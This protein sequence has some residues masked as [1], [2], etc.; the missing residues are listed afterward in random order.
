M[1]QQRVWRLEC[2]IDT[3][4]EDGIKIAVIPRVKE[5]NEPEKLVSCIGN[6]DTHAVEVEMDGGGEYERVDSIQVCIKIWFLWN[7][8]SASWEGVHPWR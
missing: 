2:I 7:R 3:Y 6:F 5:I 4:R 8:W 1:Y